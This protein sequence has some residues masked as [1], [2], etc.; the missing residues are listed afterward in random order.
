MI[1]SCLS[2]HTV[3]AQQDIPVNTAKIPLLIY[4]C[5]SHN[6]NR[7]YRFILQNMHLNGGLMSDAINNVDQSWLISQFSLKCLNKLTD[8]TVDLTLDIQEKK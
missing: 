1:F 7:I 6:D 3:G 2:P 8:N 4:A 5:V